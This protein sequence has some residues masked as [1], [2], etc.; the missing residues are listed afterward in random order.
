MGNKTILKEEYKLNKNFIPNF[1][2]ARKLYFIALAMNETNLDIDNKSKGEVLKENEFYFN[3]ESI[4]QKK[5]SRLIDHKLD[6]N[7]SETEFKRYL[8]L[9][10]KKRLKKGLKLPYNKFKWSIKENWNLTA[11]C[12]TS[13]IL[14]KAR[15]NLIECGINILPEPLYSEFKKLN[16][17]KN[18]SNSKKVLNIMLKLDLGEN[19]TAEEVLN[20]VL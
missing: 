14:N 19:W 10:H 16:I 2:K 12:E 1:I 17:L 6:Y 13:T 8:K 7:L 4:C 9:V 15:K 20:E 11:D 3:S 18:Y 5:G